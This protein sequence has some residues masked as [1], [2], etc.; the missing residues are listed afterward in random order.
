LFFPWLVIFKKEAVAEKSGTL[1]IQLEVES[2]TLTELIVIGYGTQKKTDKTG[3]VSMVK[4]EDLNKGVIT[5]RSRV[6]R[7]RQPAFQ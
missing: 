3:A 1:D 6:Y 4:S 2:T 7:E 5:I